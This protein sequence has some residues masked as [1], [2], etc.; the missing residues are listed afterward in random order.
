MVPAISKIIMFGPVLYICL[1][2][3]EEPAYSFPYIHD[4]KND[5]F[6]Q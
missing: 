5:L 6:L 4:S 3:I 1:A 2:D